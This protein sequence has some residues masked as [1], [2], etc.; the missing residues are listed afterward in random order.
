MTAPLQPCGLDL[1]YDLSVNICYHDCQETETYR[2]G[3]FSFAKN[4]L[5]S[6]ATFGA[7]TAWQ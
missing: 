6:F 1:V 7:T 2:Y 5:R 3:V 4:D